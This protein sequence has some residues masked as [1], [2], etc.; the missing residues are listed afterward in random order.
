MDAIRNLCH[1]S[2]TSTSHS[3]LNPSHRCIYVFTNVCKYA[4]VWIYDM[5]V[6]MYVW[7]YVCMYVCMCVSA[8]SS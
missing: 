8:S 7:K 4:C 6:C 5:Y 3:A 2:S 1:T